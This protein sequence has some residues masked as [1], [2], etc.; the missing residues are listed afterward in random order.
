MRVQSDDTLIIGR[1][2]AIAVEG[3]DAALDRAEAYVEAGADMLF[4]EAPQSLQENRSDRPASPVGC[5]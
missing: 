4:I 1:T 5:R 2:D 3:F